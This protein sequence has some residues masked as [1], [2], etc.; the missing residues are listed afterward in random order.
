MLVRYKYYS[1]YFR[2]LPWESGQINVLGGGG[3]LGNGDWANTHQYNIMVSYPPPP[4]MWTE[5]L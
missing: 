4:K 5:T 2:N 3:G 1:V